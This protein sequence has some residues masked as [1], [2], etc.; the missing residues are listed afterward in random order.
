MRFGGSGGQ[1][2]KGHGEKEDAIGV[3]GVESRD[4]HERLLWDV[5]RRMP[6][7]VWEC[8]RKKKRCPRRGCVSGRVT[9]RFREVDLIGGG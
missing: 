4:E 6:Q 7:A 1:E 5:H 9:E 2:K 8:H 3:V